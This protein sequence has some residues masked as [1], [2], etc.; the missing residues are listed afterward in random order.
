[1][2]A[3]LP[4]EVSETC[5]PNAL[6]SL[7]DPGPYLKHGSLC[8]CDSAV[9][10]ASRSVQSFCRAHG[11]AQLNRETDH[12]ALPTGMRN[13]S[14]PIQLTQCRFPGLAI[15]NAKINILFR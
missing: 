13:E 1:M 11:C 6:F 8:L 12:A 2:T 4:K 10:T 14:A 3:V 5:P 15:S 9:Q 7:E